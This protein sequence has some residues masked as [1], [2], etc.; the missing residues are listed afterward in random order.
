MKS[1]NVRV[2]FKVMILFISQEILAVRDQYQR[3]IQGGGWGKGGARGTRPPILGNH[4]EELQTVLFEVELTINCTFNI[5]LH[6]YYRNM[7]NT[8]TFVIW[9]TVIRFF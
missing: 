1:T 3:Q 9:Q 4:F 5:R 2:E 8:Q 7:F 6:K